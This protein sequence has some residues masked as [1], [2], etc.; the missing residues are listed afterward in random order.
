MT[1]SNSPAPIPSARSRYLW[2]TTRAWHISP[3]MSPQAKPKTCSP[4]LPHTAIRKVMW[5]G[6]R[7]VPSARAQALAFCRASLLDRQLGWHLYRSFFVR[8]RT[9]DRFAERGWRGPIVMSPLKSANF[10]IASGVAPN[11]FRLSRARAI[12]SSLTKTTF[13]GRSLTRFTWSPSF[14]ECS[15]ALRRHKRLAVE[16]H[17]PR[18]QNTHSFQL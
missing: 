16:L 13:P 3:T 14:D 5:A 17:A 4:A 8:L 1:P 9:R 2:P 12:A 11:A 15:S 6:R 18:S 7:N 10:F